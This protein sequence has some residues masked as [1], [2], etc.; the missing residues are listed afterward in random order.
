MLDL[1][2]VI[3]PFRALAWTMP[4]R[5]VF[6]NFIYIEFA[7]GGG[8][9]AFWDEGAGNDST[10]KPVRLAGAKRCWP[11]EIVTPANGCIYPEGLEQPT[12]TLTSSVAGTSAGVGTT[13][14]A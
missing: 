7:G 8:G 11:G 10:S 1:E 5:F 13:Q 3:Y 4:F 2:E 9:L 6:A 12:L 14:P